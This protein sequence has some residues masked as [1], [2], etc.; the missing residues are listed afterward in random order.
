MNAFGKTLL[1]IWVLSWNSSS[2]AQIEKLEP[3]HWWTGFKHQSL[4]LLIYGDGMASCTPTL[5]YPGV[6]LT[7]FHK[8]D[9]PNYL[10]LDL[11][12]S[13]EAKA[14]E[15]SI[16][17]RPEKGK[18][19]K[20]KYKL[21]DREEG[22][23]GFDSSDVIYLITPDRFANGNLSNDSV[24]GLLEQGVNRDDDYARHGGDIQ[25][26]RDHLDYIQEMGFTALWSSP[27][28]ENDMAE[29]SY[30]GYAI[31][32]YYAVDPRFGSLEE[33][34]KLAHECQK[35]G[36]K[37]I[38]D[39]VANHCGRNHWWMRDLPFSDWLNFQD[40]LESGEALPNSNHRRTTHQDPYASEAD[41]EAMTKGWFVD[42][43]PDLNQKN[44]FLANY[45]IQNSLWWIE[46][47]KLGGIRQDTYPYPDKAFMSQWAGRIMEEYP[48]FSIVGEEWSYNPLMVGYWLQGANNRDGY[49]SHLSSSMDFP[50]QK[51]LKEALIEE[52]SWDK[53]LTKLYEGL[54][55]DFHY[56]D[57]Q[58]LMFFADNHDMDRIAT[59]LNEDPKLIRM[60]MT[61]LL[62][63]P[64]IPQV[65][66]GT[67]IL[68]QNSAEPGD[69]GLIRTDFPGGWKGDEVNA[70]RGYGLN[71]AQKEMQDYMKT[72]LNFRKDSKLIHSGK[73]RH[74]APQN[75]VYTFFRYNKDEVLMLILNKNEQEWPLEMSRFKEMKLSGMNYQN[76]ITGKQGVFTRRLLLPSRSTTLLLFKK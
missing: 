1:L 62:V 23:K 26:I 49:E 28:L 19:I 53:G 22:V 6:E 30:H 15:V 12:I 5:E 33:Y 13:A 57:P 60:A 8:G 17:L 18:R 4:Q 69:H 54:A 65:Y 37:L 75:G 31:T 58:S 32:D 29:Q 50:L 11:K 36:I 70:F 20:L 64:R 72:L 39:Q 71:S 68:M 66:Y 24:K 25:G 9:S 34:K 40:S 45:L 61:F 59:Q 51:A 73:T 74:F 67:E 55:N 41:G 3:P 35:R 48:D 7:G 38:M 42:A 27:L 52:E 43:M 14:G 10:F 16:Y 76:I 21:L 56:S 2:W 47:L 46:S 44:E 63:S